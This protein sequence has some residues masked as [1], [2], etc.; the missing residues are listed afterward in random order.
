MKECQLEGRRVQDGLANPGSVHVEQDHPTSE[1]TFFVGVGDAFV[2]VE[3]VMPSES[4]L[5]ASLED[6]TVKHSSTPVGIPLLFNR[7]SRPG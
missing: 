7:P 4:Q 5:R 6:C 3:V 2:N 1:R